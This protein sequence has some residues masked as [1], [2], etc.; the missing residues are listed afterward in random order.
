MIFQNPILIKMKPNIKGWKEIKIKLKGLK[1]TVIK[2]AAL[3]KR[4]SIQIHLIKNIRKSSAVQ[5]DKDLTVQ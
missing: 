5:I 4:N 1:I 2:K 3:I